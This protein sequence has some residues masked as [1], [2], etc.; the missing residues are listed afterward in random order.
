[1]Q[2]DMT[3]PGSPTLFAVARENKKKVFN[4]ITL[5][6]FECKGSKEEPRR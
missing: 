5:R 3:G 2:H 6:G 4:M 1:M